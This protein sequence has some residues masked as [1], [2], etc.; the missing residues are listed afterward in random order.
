MSTFRPLKT[1]LTLAGL[2]A[3]SSGFAADAMSKE[4]QKAAKDRIEATFK[5]DKAACAKMEGNTKDIC[6]AEAKAKQKVAQAELD[7]QKSGKDSDK[8]KVARVKAEQDYEIAKEKCEEPSVADKGA[9][10]KEAKATQ[11]KAIADVKAS[12]KKVAGKS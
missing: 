3:V 6:N 1:A 12:A 11:D 10:K 5:S 9:C 4:D 7:A 2:L 8:A